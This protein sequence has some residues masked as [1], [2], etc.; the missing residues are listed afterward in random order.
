MKL[1]TAF[2]RLVRWPNL[3]FIALT[4]FLFYYCIIVP[5]L[6][7]KYFILPNS[8]NTC[9]FNLIVVASVMIAAGGYIINDYFDIDIDQ[10]NKPDKMVIEKSISRRW[11]ILFHWVFTT[12]GI[13][14]S[15]YVS[16]HTTWI[17]FITNVVSTFLLWVYSTTFKK[18]L[19]SGNI[20]I[21]ALTAWT[22]LILY[23]AT[24]TTYSLPLYR[25][26]D[27]AVPMKRIFKFSVSYAAFAFIISLIREAVKD[28][29]DMIGD[30]KYN[31]KTMPIAWGI[32]ASKVYSGVWII[33]LT[34]ALL[35]VQVYALLS[36]WWA[37][38]L[39]TVVLI[40]APLI[41][42]LQHLYRAQ[43]IR[44][45]HRLSTLIKLIMLAGIVS[46]LFFKIYLD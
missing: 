19:L 22:I 41:Y 38:A 16:L 21:A 33:V 27:F 39:Y 29:E 7:E 5:A 36:G 12:A 15:L 6:P 35:I 23:F 18:K 8:I 43:E 4:Q 46:I 1:I 9:I 11:A 30:A 3:L 17:V 40:I 10:V 42:V 44:Q 31:C 26:A 2:L 28:M 14:I 13:C 34:G 20:I 24:N 32:P 25:M 45:Y 37:S